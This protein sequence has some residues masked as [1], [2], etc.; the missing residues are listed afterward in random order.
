MWMRP[1]RCVLAFLVAGAVALAAAP[2]RADWH[3]F[4]FSTDATGL[5]ARKAAFEAGAG[6]NGLPQPEVL[7]PADQK[8][9]D[10]WI[11]AAV[12]LT[13]WLMLDG[14]VAFADG[15][16][17]PYGFGYG[18]VE[19]R[20]QFLAPRPK[21]PLS[22]AVGAGW[23]VDEQADHA[24]TGVFAATLDLG[25][26]VLTANVRVAHYFAAGRDPVDV[27]LTAG[28]SVRATRWLRVGAE[29]VGEELEGVD[30][31]G[32]AEVG[33]GGRHYLGPSFLFSALH[34]R[35][36]FNLTAG[37]VLTRAS[38]AALAR[39]ALVYLF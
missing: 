21:L 15:P 30:Q 27:A 1:T 31:D 32:E 7:N 17:R 36:R 29:Y 10:A 23:Q 20:A 19:L 5:A 12:G 3:T 16:E 18:R 38:T 4:M 8:R 11:G 35:L 22:L 25:R 34:D 33:G 28:V 2:A 39:G 26:V 6:Y 24:L 14:A 13:R 9:T 37:P